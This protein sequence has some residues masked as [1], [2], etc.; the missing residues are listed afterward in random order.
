M[1]KATA[2]FVVF[3]LIPVLVHA[4]GEKVLVKGHALGETPAE[5]AAIDQLDCDRILKLKP[6]ELR[7][8]AL[9]GDAKTCR[10]LQSAKDGRRIVV[11][12]SFQQDPYRGYGAQFDAG[13]VV[14][15]TFESPEFT[16]V[17]QDLNERFGKPAETRKETY[18][19]NVGAS[20]EASSA[21]WDLPGGAKIVAREGF[22]NGTSVRETN[23]A[24]FAPGELEKA[25]A[26]QKRRSVL[27]K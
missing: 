19:N 23:V 1:L 15:I 5:F 14:G 6:K 25:E 8:H 24:F 2:S 18:E 10:D 20:Y 17:L 3:A 22:V 9:E 7:K 21:E 12:R 27:D 26:R 11:L 16:T 4:Q 13:H